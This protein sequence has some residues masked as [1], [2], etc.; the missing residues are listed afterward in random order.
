MY[1][2]NNNPKSNAFLFNDALVLLNKDMHK[3]CHAKVDNMFGQKKDNT[4][5]S[6]VNH[7]IPNWTPSTRSD[8]NR[9]IVFNNADGIYDVNIYLNLITVFPRHL[10]DMTKFG[11]H[12]SILINFILNY[13]RMIVPDSLTA[14]FM[15]FKIAVYYKNE[16][17]DGFNVNRQ[18]TN[19]TISGETLPF[20]CCEHLRVLT[21]NEKYEVVE[22]K[23][24]GWGGN[25]WSS[26]NNVNPWSMG[27]NTN[28][29]SSGNNNSWGNNNN[30]SWNNNSGNNWN[31][32]NNS[33]GGNWSGSSFNTNSWMKN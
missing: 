14:N 5:L 8:E 18:S 28:P 3:V 1:T 24:N 22:E 17:L 21:F 4:W 12:L 30:N 31:G 10:P 26:N 11:F 7:Y 19:K 29:W 13:I 32:N 20:E 23:S 33:W 15:Q 6:C 27:N 9:T 25:G 16:R 2:Q